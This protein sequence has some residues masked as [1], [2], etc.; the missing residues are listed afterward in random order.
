MIEQFIPGAVGS[1]T[2]RKGAYQ[3]PG[4][5]ALVRRLLYISESCR[6]KPVISPDFTAP[7]HQQAPLNQAPHLHLDHTL[8]GVCICVVCVFCIII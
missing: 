1:R 5:I 4:V 2:F 6:F 7:V 3:V 8:S